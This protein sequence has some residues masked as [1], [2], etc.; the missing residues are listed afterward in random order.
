MSGSTVERSEIGSETD[1]DSDVWVEVPLDF[2]VADLASAEE[3]ADEFVADAL[4][5]NPNATGTAESVREAA[6]AVAAFT[7][8]F[9]SR[10]FWYF[11]LEARTLALVQLFELPRDA[12]LES[13]L[14]EVLGEHDNRATDPVVTEMV[15]TT[16]ERIVRVAFL[17][18]EGTGDASSVYGTM[19]VARVSDSSI[20]LFELI[21][22]DLF[23]ASTI[24]SDL[25]VLAASV[26]RGPFSP[27]VAVAAAVQDAV[28]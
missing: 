11:P 23:A 14:A 9:E 18:R 19:R 27:G 24:I 12:E 28:E 13:V 7:R 6:L 26:G 4:R 21:D 3:W 20:D 17:A 16:G 25:E 2:P 15:S 5:E 22:Q 10:R 8:G 1:Y